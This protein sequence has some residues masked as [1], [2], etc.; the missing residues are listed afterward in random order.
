MNRDRAL[1]LMREHGVRTIIGAT[2][3][4]VCYLTGHVGWAQYV[5][6]NLPCVAAF[7][8]DESLGTDLVVPR[9]DTPYHAA[10]PSEAE[11][12]SA[13]GGRAGL[14]GGDR[15]VEATDEEDRF[16]VLQAACER[17][18][19]PAAALADRLRSRG[20]TSG[21]VV[22]DDIYAGA[23]L[24]SGLRHELPGVDFVEGEGLFLMIRLIKTA[25]EIAKLRAAAVVNE[26]GL[27]HALA[28]IASGVPETEVARVWREDVS[29]AGGKPLWFHLGSGARSAYV[30]P[31]TS[32]SFAPGD[33][34]MIDAGMTFDGFF[35]DAGTC[36]SIGEPRSQ[37]EREWQAVLTAF[38][39][40]A[41]TLRHGVRGS[42]V[43]EALV[44]S[45]PTSALGDAK[46]PFAGHTIGM[47]AREF[48]FVLGKPALVDIPFL[49]LTTDI[50]LPAG[51]TVNIELPIGRLG[52]G[53]YQIEKTYVIGT[54]GADELIDYHR[55]MFV[56]G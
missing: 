1:E 52:Y 17:F 14:L 55:D 25:A 18:A 42:T 26:Q 34:F 53:G 31:P 16:A 7:T 36:G 3:E 21:T 19:T 43:Y 46:V 4:N 15:M 56:A 2:P 35:S 38:E 6:R 23:E 54:D 5:Y 13:Y 8:D 32:R 33:L 44:R 24:M 48:P 10:R 50:E 27:Q 45:L 22:V 30:F 49:P 20:V 37:S 40:S 47:E 9:S 29:G 11:H 51:A 39:E 41:A 12:V 28:G